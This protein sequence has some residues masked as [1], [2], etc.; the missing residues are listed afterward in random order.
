MNHVEIPS[1]RVPNRYR[2]NR[3]PTRA[4]QTIAGRA[5]EEQPHSIGTWVAALFISGRWIR[6]DYSAWAIIIPAI[7]IASRK[8]GGKL[9]FASQQRL[10]VFAWRTGANQSLV[11]IFLH[12]EQEL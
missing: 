6:T 7:S 4:S 11:R 10:N 1:G 3:N 8:S 5:R 9:E 12:R 2:L